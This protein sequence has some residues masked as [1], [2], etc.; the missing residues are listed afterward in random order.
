[1]G[2]DGEAKDTLTGDPAHGLAHLY[3]GK[4]V[5]QPGVEV[6]GAGTD[7]VNGWYA[8]KE[9]AEGP[10]SS[11]P[12]QESD[13]AQWNAGR[14][15]Y[16]KDDGCIVYR[17]RRHWRICAPDG[18]WRYWQTTRSDAPAGH[19]GGPPPGQGWRASSG[20][21]PAPTLRVVP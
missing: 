13:W 8:R 10:P 18:N 12:Y 21:A 3:E 4:F 11:W 19:R 1:M 5:Q 20:R 17:G 15:W 14:H 6:T 9:A 7:A 2:C 16:E